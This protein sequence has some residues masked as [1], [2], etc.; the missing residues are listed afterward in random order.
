MIKEVAMAGPVGSA[1]LAAWEHVNI[2]WLAEDLGVPKSK[3]PHWDDS[4][5]DSVLVLG[6]DDAAALA[7]FR[8]DAEHFNASSTW[9]H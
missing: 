1:V 8:V 7:S 3:L 6:F 5:Y 2:Q 9:P 4:N